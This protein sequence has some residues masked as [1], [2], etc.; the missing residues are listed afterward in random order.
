MTST[1][2]SPEAHYYSAA[3]SSTVLKHPMGAGIYVPQEAMI[4][5]SAVPAQLQSHKSARNCDGVLL[6][7]NVML[8]RTAVA[9]G[10]VAT[11]VYIA[12]EYTNPYNKLANEWLEVPV[13][14]A[15]SMD[16]TLSQPAIN[17]MHE[18]FRNALN[19]FGGK[20]VSSYF[21]QHG[22]VNTLAVSVR[23]PAQFCNPVDS[24][25]ARESA[26]AGVNIKD[27]LIPVA[28]NAPSRGPKT[29]C[30]PEAPDA[31]LSIPCFY[32]SHAALY[33]LLTLAGFD[34]MEILRIWNSARAVRH[35]F[36]ACYGGEVSAFT[37]ENGKV[38]PWGV[39]YE[40]PRAFYPS[41]VG[42]L[43]KDSVIPVAAS[44]MPQPDTK[45]HYL[46]VF[47]SDECAGWHIHVDGSRHKKD[48]MK[49]RK[50][51]AR[52][53]VSLL[54]LDEEPQ[55]EP[56]A[57]KKAVAALIDKQEG[58]ADGLPTANQSGTVS[59][60]AYD[61]F[62]SAPEPCSD[63]PR[64]GT[65]LVKTEGELTNKEFADVLFQFA[66]EMRRKKVYDTVFRELVEAGAEAYSKCELFT[67]AQPEVSQN[68][69][70]DV[71]AAQAAFEAALTVIS[72]RT[73]TPYVAGTFAF[74]V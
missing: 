52:G 47:S 38:V 42:Q 24:R 56:D 43:S 54:G 50:D 46:A 8:T 51:E 64:A 4:A 74:N 13:D 33:A 31:V 71:D 29:G 68:R 28:P 18:S 65:P 72:T 45:G 32:A 6:S 61:S 44:L 60:A 1:C 73:S 25:I 17:A 26:W 58:A 62:W 16:L 41:T 30:V 20:T 9:T 14:S 10:L 70:A 2:I 7:P 12:S 19:S 22:T 35:G 37:M 11:F 63:L 69:P 66:S 57:P 3:P 36:S 49:A 5:C 34:N 15:S 39:G 23:M 48:V 53:V 40:N 55:D 21:T 67:P 27:I 59:A